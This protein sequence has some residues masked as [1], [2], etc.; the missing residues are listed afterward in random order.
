MQRRHLLQGLAASVLPGWAHAQADWPTR[1]LRM[2]VPFPPGGTTDG[3][4]RRVAT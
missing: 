3:G 2:I 1:P 4:T